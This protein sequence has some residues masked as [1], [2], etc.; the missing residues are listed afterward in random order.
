M[1]YMDTIEI[2]AKVGGIGGMLIAAIR[3]ILLPRL[4]LQ[5]AQVKPECDA[6]TRSHVNARIEEAR[7]Y[8]RQNFPTREE[9][10]VVKSD[11]RHTKETVDGIDRKLAELCNTVNRR[12]D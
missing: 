10:A 2:I 9:F 6:Y 11:I 3:F 12:R 1:T 7:E 8:S 4:Q 5:I